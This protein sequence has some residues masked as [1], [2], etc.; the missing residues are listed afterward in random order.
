M[1]KTAKSL[2]SFSLALVLL[3]GFFPVTAFAT[4]ICTARDCGCICYIHTTVPEMG[5]IEAGNYHSVFL[6]PDGTV[7]AVGSEKLSEYANRGTRC[8]VW[9]WEGIVQVSAASHT[10]GLKSDGTV[11]QTG[12]CD[13]WKRNTDSW[14][15]I[16]AISAGAA[17]TLGLREDGSVAAVGGESANKGQCDVNG[18]YDIVAI[19]AGMHHS[20]GLMA[21]GTIV[22]A[23]NNGYHQCDIAD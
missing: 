23:G 12:S 22:A 11:V 19:S 3:A 20:L 14:C 8:D 1:K 17:Y 5:M 15:D 16:I 18:W 4:D 6:D 9:D 10:V 7:F 21:D 13:Q 2:V